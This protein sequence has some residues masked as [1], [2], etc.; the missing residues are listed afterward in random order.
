MNQLREN[1][2]NL[3]EVEKVLVHIPA[4]SVNQDDGVDDLVENVQTSEA[5]NEYEDKSIDK[6][7]IKCR[8]RNTGCGNSNKEIPSSI[9]NMETERDQIVTVESAINS[10][11][12]FSN[13]N[14]S[15]SNV[16]NFLN[17]IFKYAAS[18]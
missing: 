2:K 5:P 18:N 8:P 10:T 11:Q 13:V 15:N 14:V 4:N 9:T 7:E 1:E 3:I 17:I 6:Y 16:I 12:S